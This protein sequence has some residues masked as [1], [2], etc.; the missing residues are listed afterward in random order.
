MTKVPLLPSPGLNTAYTK[1]HEWI[2]LADNGRKFKCERCGASYEM[3]LPAPL[4]VYIAACNAF[5]RSH[6]RC[7]VQK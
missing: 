3:N 4:D 1:R 6:K 5:L 7:K 2:L